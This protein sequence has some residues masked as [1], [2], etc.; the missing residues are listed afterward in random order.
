M[1]DSYSSHDARR[2]TRSIRLLAVVLTVMAC[3][4]VPAVA[5][6]A[7]SDTVVVRRGLPPEPSVSPGGAFLRSLVLPAWGHAA[8]ESGRGAFYTFAEAGSTWMFFRVRSRISSARDRLEVRTAAARA[9]AVAS[10]ITDE[11]EIL[12]AVQE[13]E[14]VQDALLLVDA[15]EGQREDWV[16][17]MIFS[18]LLSGVDAYVSAHLQ[19]FPDPLSSGF[20]PSPWGGVEVVGRVHLPIGW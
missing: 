19:G 8:V 1:L 11:G 4:S 18:V 13:D 10:G 17:L 7:E 9:E 3:T 20:Q 6:T 12:I 5:Q 2:L 14:G 16:A 15:R